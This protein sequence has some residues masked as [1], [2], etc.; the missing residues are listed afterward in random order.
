MKQSFSLC[1]FDSNS[2]SLELHRSRFVFFSN[3]TEWLIFLE[4]TML[5][6]K[7]IQQKYMPSKRELIVSRLDQ[8]QKQLH[9]IFVSQVYL[10]EGK[11]Q[12]TLSLFRPFS[13]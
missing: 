2:H 8:A 1:V 3:E 13:R 12:K 5:V 4:Q 11:L 10:S 7:L 9:P 6:Q